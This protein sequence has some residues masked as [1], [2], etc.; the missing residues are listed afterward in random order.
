MKY[1]NTDFIKIN[2]YISWPL[3]YHRCKITQAS[4]ITEK[5]KL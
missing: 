3:K 5:G 1:N 4:I 2:I